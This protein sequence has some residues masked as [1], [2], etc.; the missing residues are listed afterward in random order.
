MQYILTQEEYDALRARQQHEIMM[1]RDQ[2]QTLC[3]EIADTMPI[4]RPWTKD[5]EPW[6]CILTVNSDDMWCCDHCP[7][8]K[9]C[10]NPYKEWSK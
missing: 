5:L 2:L 7:V 1:S 10:P 9:I 4:K 8:Q 3:C 6:G